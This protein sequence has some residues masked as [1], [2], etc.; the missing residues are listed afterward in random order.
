[1]KLK[2][3][4]KKKKAMPKGNMQQGKQQSGPEPAQH[5]VAQQQTVGKPA[6]PQEPKELMKQAEPMKQPRAQQQPLP[7]A[8]PQAV[9]PENFPKVISEISR[10]LNDVFLFENLLTAVLVFLVFYLI[11]AIFSLPVLVAAIG[12]LCYLV[13]SS[14]RRMRENKILTV[15]RHYPMLREKLRTSA[16][17]RY[18]RNNPVVSELQHQIINTLK[19]VETGHFINLR[20]MTVKIGL[21]I[22]LAFA[23]V[24]LPATG[25]AFNHLHYKKIADSIGDTISSGAK[26]L[27]DL[28]KKDDNGLLIGDNEEIFG[29]ESL[30]ILGDEEVSFAIS[31]VSF[32]VDVKQ[33]DE[34]Q[35]Y[36]V[37]FEYAAEVD[38]DLSK[39]SKEKREIIKRYFHEIQNV[40]Q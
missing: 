15:E 22:L 38:D 32:D 20:S 6:A 2:L 18:A 28:L 25:I 21:T 31:P 26:T 35:T 14:V 37:L 33:E 16:D 23:L 12:A 9:K 1:M 7:Q 8:V 36:D 13:V 10:S 27:Q 34:D 4:I 17:T 3:P 19:D 40:Q 29:E 30:A 11:I 24:T 39:L 5:P